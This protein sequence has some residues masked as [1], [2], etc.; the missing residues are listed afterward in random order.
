[1]NNKTLIIIVLL[2]FFNSI[3]GQQIASVHNIKIESKILNQERELLIYTPPSY[4]ENTLVSYDVI[5]VFDAQN[6]EFFDYTTSVISFISNATKKYIVVG[7]TSLYIEKLEYARNNDLLP[8][9]KTDDSKKRYGKYSGN[10]DN[11]LGYV[12]NEVVPFI[13]NNYRTRSNKVAIGHSLS[14]SFI[15]YSMFKEPNLFDAYF[16]ISPNFAYDNERLTTELTDF[17]YQRIKEKTFLYISNANEGVD[18]WK[19]WEPARKK[20]YSFL[21]NS[22]NLDKIN[23]VVKSFPEETHWTTFAPSLT[24]G[25]TEY[26]KYLENKTITFSDETYEITL[27]LKVPNKTDEVYVTGNQASLGDWNP[28]LVKMKHKTDFEREIKL[29]VHTPSELKFTRGTWETEG[30]V[31]YVGGFDNIRINPKKQTEFEFEIIEWAD[32][33]Q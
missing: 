26:F 15:L 12:K 1:M 9:L 24:L 13:E 25:L 31:K 7:I 21:E 23:S 14:A 3:F 30:L 5:Y 32:K 2:L 19:E 20:V 17:D 29:K 11:F 18:Y 8:I 10:A 22:N 27:N 6:R 28:A 4:N 33:M 16:A